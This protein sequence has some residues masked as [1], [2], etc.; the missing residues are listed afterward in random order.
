MSHQV[1]LDDDVFAVL[2]KMAVPLVD[3]INS[4]LRRL[5]GVESPADAVA[6][7]PRLVAVPVADG[8]NRPQGSKSR[9]TG[10][11]KAVAKEKDKKPRAARGTTLPASEYELPML[12][13][14]VKHGGR[15]PATEVIEEL[16]VAL[17]SRLTP[18]DRD[19]VSSGL[20]R[21]KNRAQFV[22]LNLIKAGDMVKG[23]PR[24]MW[25]ISDKGRQRLKGASV[26]EGVGQ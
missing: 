6:S 3:D 2:Q 23:S 11:K 1:N 21:W 9:M 12:A 7:A 4:V 19:L 5:L 22:R 14:L 24:G 10:K 20:V 17:A 8:P 18:A 13:V 15:A 16:G 26:S 25:E